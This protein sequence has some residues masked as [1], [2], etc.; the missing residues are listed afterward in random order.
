MKKIT[1]LCILT[2]CAILPIDAQTLSLDS[3]RA[4][5]LRNNK[6]LSIS[7]AKLK[8]AENARKAARTKYLPHV[9]IAGGW[10]LTS[11]EISILNNDQKSMLSNLGTNNIAPVS[12][13]MGEILNKMHEGNIINDQQFA[14]L[15]KIAQ[16]VGG[17]LAGFGNKIGNEIRDAFRTDTRSIIAGS[18]M[19]N[20]PVFMGGAITAGNRM[21]D[22][23]EKIASTQIDA[24]EQNILYDIDKTYW[25]VVSLK[26]KQRLADSF[27]ELVGK[28]NSD[29]HKMIENGVATR[30]DGLKVDVA[31]NEAEMTKTEVDNG[32]ALSRMLLCQLCGMPLTSDVILTDENN[33]DGLVSV[34]IDKTYDHSIAV[35]NR[36]ELQMLEDAV[37]LTEQATKLTRA[38]ILPQVAITGGY[39][40]S[41]PNL[42]NGFEKKFSGMW[43]IGLLVRIP[44]FDWGDNMYKVR[45]TKV[46]TDM[47]R[48]EYDEAKELIEL[49]V[50]Q[51]DYKLNEARKKL[52]TAEK[53][54]KRAEENLRCAN[55]GFSE[56]VMQISEVMA[57]QTAWLQAKTQKIDAEIGVRLSEA[58]MKKA[59]GIR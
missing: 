29:V 9:D 41:N 19:I 56:G 58:G 39:M 44:V 17:E 16:Q 10:F 12:N 48:M 21:A 8:V 57:A 23:A 50:S 38:G 55:L 37:A 47:A 22:I 26:Q 18:V 51:N 31:L 32:L 49:Q 28:L 5:A 46:A 7:R 30:A 42:Y 2:L 6:Q 33:V 14:G 36:P 4:M 59:L 20:Q 15:S 53:N 35:A 11:K 13:K 40:L 25:L 45:A 24:S 43:N 27:V 54:I 52:I 3:C 1:T 34:N